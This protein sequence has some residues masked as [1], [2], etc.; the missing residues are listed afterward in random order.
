MC[1][2][3]E[4]R[5]VEL[6]VCRCGVWN[7]CRGLRNRAMWS[8]PGV[9][10][11]VAGTWTQVFWW[12]RMCASPLSHLSGP[13][14]CPLNLGSKDET[15]VSAVF[16]MCVCVPVTWIQEVR[17]Q[18]P[19]VISLLPLCEFW[20]WTRIVRLIGKQPYPGSHFTVPILSPISIGFNVTLLKRSTGQQ[21]VSVSHTSEPWPW[22]PCLL[23]LSFWLL[24]I[25]PLISWQYSII[26]NYLVP[27]F[28][29]VQVPFLYLG[30]KTEGKS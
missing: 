11:V 24:H 4:V 25:P 26:Q 12:K 21:N 1:L 8:P 29:H 5:G 22:P 3:V 6:C 19:G 20:H 13:F 17:G 14:R 23:R 10:D 27:R 18:F 16:I 15:C 28:F 7:K 9:P 2:C 30:Y